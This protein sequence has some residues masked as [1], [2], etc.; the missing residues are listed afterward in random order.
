M[1]KPQNTTSSRYGQKRTLTPNGHGIYT[2]EGDAHYYR[3]GMN[4]DNT[5]IAY[6][7]PEGG[8]FI[9]VGSELDRFSGKITDIIVEKA[10]Q[11]RF[12]IRLEIDS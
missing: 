8:P 4:E 1:N 12:K 11:G 9:A 10:P 3:V 5:K 2:M 6:F 7:D